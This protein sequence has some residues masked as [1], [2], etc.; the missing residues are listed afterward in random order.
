MSE[1]VLSQNEQ[2]SVLDA[3]QTP[4]TP[5]AKRSGNGIAVV[6]LLLGAAGFV[7]AVRR[8]RILVGGDP[9]RNEPY[10]YA[11]GRGAHG[12]V[13][14]HNAHFATRGVTLALR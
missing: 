3:P 9:F 5:P 12:L 13:F 8:L 14:L 10:G 1:T 2:P 4:V 7:V 6:A 11:H